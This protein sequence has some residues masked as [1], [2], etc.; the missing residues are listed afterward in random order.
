MREKLPHR[1]RSVI[2]TRQP[3]ALPRVCGVAILNSV[4]VTISYDRVTIPRQVFVGSPQIYLLHPVTIVIFYL[5]QSLNAFIHV[6]FILDNRKRGVR[7]L[8][9]RRSGPIYTRYRFKIAAE[10]LRWILT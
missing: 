10:L 9:S 1:V 4:Q 8:L 7:E 5:F 6:D 3:I 2:Y